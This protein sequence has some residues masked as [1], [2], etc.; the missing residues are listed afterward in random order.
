MP[1]ASTRSLSSAIWALKP[2]SMVAAPWATVFA[3][4][5]DVRQDL[6]VE[7]RVAGEG[8]FFGAYIA[9]GLDQGLEHRPACLGLRECLLQNPVRL[10]PVATS[11]G[12]DCLVDI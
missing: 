4:L 11:R 5:L 10:I 1:T 7:V 9:A 3:V 2:L 6:L 8:A 12:L